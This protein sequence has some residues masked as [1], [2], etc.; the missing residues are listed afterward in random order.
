MRG[1]SAQGDRV[2]EHYE[3]FWFRRPVVDRGAYVQIQEEDLCSKVEQVLIKFLKSNALFNK[4]YVER[5]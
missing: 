2:P 3:K 5:E 1:T 4:Q